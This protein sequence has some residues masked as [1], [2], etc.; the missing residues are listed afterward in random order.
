M[1]LIEKEGMTLMRRQD[2]YVNATALCKSAGRELKSYLRTDG[3]KAFIEELADV[4]Q[5]CT[6]DLVQIKQGGKPEE[7]GTYVHPLVAV[8]LGQWLSPKFA[9]FVSMVIEGKFLKPLSQEAAGLVSAKRYSWSP[10]PKSLKGRIKGLYGGGAPFIYGRILEKAVGEE[11]AEH[12]R[13][14]AGK[15]ARWMWLSPAGLYQLEAYASWLDM[16]TAPVQ[17]RT[18][19]ESVL[20]GRESNYL[21]FERVPAKA[22]K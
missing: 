17:T 5:I 13:H 19:F 6:T 7:Q 8:N 11:A 20:F 3:T 2:G 14:T 16:H 22:G 4:V 18:D 12:L 9:V 15:G 10:Y 21:P 1:E